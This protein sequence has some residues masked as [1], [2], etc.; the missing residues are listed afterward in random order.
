MAIHAITS[1]ARFG[2]WTVTSST[3]K[4][5]SRIHIVCRCDCGTEKPIRPEKLR[6]GSSTSCGCFARDS[7]ITHGLT[8]A[9]IRKTSHEYWI[10]NTMKQRCL[11]HRHAAYDNYGGRGIQL[12][13]SWHSFENFYR[14][15]GPRPSVKHSIDRI[16]ND[17]NYEPWNCRWVERIVQAQN[18]RNNHFLTANGETQCLAEWSRRLG[19]CNGTILGRLKL[20]WSEE[21]AVTVPV[22]RFSSWEQA[23]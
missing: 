23:A 16:D 20:G 21:R 6:N 9:A 5:K 7:L 8:A 2:R 13:P 18:K 22:R 17:G 11:N 1:G 14:D 19:C 3:T 12:H 15:M 10:W 4:I